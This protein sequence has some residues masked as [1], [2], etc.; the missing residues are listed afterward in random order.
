MLERK[1]KFVENMQKLDY[2]STIHPHYCFYPF[3]TS[4]CHYMDI[5]LTLFYYV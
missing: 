4:I 5:P 2:F 3:V 1:K